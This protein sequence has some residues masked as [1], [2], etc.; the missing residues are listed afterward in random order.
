MTRYF[1]LFAAALCT[2]GCSTPAPELRFVPTATVYRVEPQPTTSGEFRDAERQGYLIAATGS[3]MA[4]G[5]DDLPTHLEAGAPLHVLQVDPRT[6]EALVRRLDDNT[7]ARV[8]LEGLEV[9]ATTYPDR[10]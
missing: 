1:F 6:G 9:R 2:A 5:I 7:F 4:L 3:E 8:N 10:Y